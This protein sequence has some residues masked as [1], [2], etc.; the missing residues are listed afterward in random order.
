MRK[1]RAP[2]KAT[3]LALQ[4]L[5]EAPENLHGYEI[6][7]ITGI[8]PG[9]L[10][11]MLARLEDQG[12]LASQWQEAEVGGRPPRHIYSLTAAGRVMAKGLLDDDRRASPQ[13]LQAK[14]T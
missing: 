3:R 7:Q 12:M 6:M 4:A 5:L 13:Q 2:S 11:P 8:G 1:T 14:P 9:T 10:Y